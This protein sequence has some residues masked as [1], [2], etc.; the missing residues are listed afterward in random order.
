MDMDSQSP[1]PLEGR[2]VCGND[3]YSDLVMGLGFTTN[4]T[5]TTIATIKN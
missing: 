4:T 5:N 1:Q 3:V 2:G